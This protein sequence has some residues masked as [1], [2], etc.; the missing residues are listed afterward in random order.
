MTIFVTGAGGFVGSALCAALVSRGHR[1]RAGVRNSEVRPGPGSALRTGQDICSI[2]DISSNPKWE[3]LLPG[4]D[5]VIHLAAL[6]HQMGTPPTL[7]AFRRINLDATE[8]LAKACVRSGVRRLVFL[9]SVKVNGESTPDGPF[10]ENLPP[11][12][13]DPYGISKMEAELVLERLSQT[14]SLETV[15]VRPPLVYGPGVRAN[16]RR[17][18]G[19]VERMNPLVIPSLKSKRSL[20]GLGNLV[21]FLSVCAEHPQAVNQTFLVSDREDLTVSELMQRIASAMG[22]K[23]YLVPASEG[24]LRF[25]ARLL[26][27][28]DEI[29]RIL[30]P[31]TVSSQKSLDMLNWTPPFSVSSG[32]DLTAKW[33]RD[34]KT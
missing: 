23:S 14:G 16:F 33:Y 13:L 19:I 34:L 28:G 1:V 2:G 7:G 27:R 11:A 15:S 20:V 29:R 17:L 22:R 10:T 5:V 26:G 21:D 18:L 25:V 8:Q 3:D 9:S 4:T 6:V 30:D 12:P 32:L 24:T 31:L